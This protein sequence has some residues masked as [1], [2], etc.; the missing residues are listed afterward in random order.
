MRSEEKLHLQRRSMLKIQLYVNSNC[1]RQITPKTSFYDFFLSMSPET[2]GF[3]TRFHPPC[4][5]F[6]DKAMVL[7]ARLGLNRP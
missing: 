2:E 5:C 6:G 7:N 3:I 4:L 1:D